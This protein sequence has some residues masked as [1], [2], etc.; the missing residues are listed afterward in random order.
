MA[1]QWD[2]CRVNGGGVVVYTPKLI[3][4]L[5]LREFIDAHKEQVNTGKWGNDM[6]KCICLLLADGW[7]PYSA[8]ND[9]Y[10]RR[11]HQG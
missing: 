5:S 11:K 8:E 9:Y 2:M 10:F 6:G 3:S 7:Q 1:E 4:S